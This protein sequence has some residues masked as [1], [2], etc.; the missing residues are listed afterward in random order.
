[1]MRSVVVLC[2]VAALLLTSVGSETTPTRADF[3]GTADV[4]LLSCPN[5]N[6]DAGNAVSAPDINV[7]ISKFGTAF[8]NFSFSYLYDRNA[9][10]AVSATDINQTI[11]RFGNL[12]PAV[13]GQIA[14]ATLAVIALGTGVLDCTE[15]A[16]N[17]AGYIRTTT[18]VPGQGVHYSNLSYNDGVFDPEHPEGLVC[19]SPGGRLVAQLYNVQGSVVGWIED[20]GP[21]PAVDPDA[22]SCWDGEDNG[23]DG[24]TD[25]ADADCGAGPTTGA[26]L[27]DVDI[28]ELCNVSGCSWA[29]DEGWHTHF[30]LCTVQI[31]SPGTYTQTMAPGEGAAEC[32][33]LHNSCPI[34]C[35]PNTTWA[36]NERVGWMGHLWNHRL[37]ENL[38][39]D[40]GSM[41]GRFADCFPDPGSFGGPWK[42]FDCPQ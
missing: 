16:M 5:V 33:L 29:G 1:M 31:P 42:A 36:Y 28:D 37:N 11:V 41:N 4:P 22:G 9:D 3:P 21:G 35:Y 34:G 30:R 2:A 38:I 32:Q 20:P 14:K 6:G 10:N 18:D 27:D 23:D 15:S 12:C 40:N 24:Q 17:A 8:P 7:A 39:A 26:A 19:D 25:A 13:D